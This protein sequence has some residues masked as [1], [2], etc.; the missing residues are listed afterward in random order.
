MLAVEHGAGEAARADT[1]ELGGQHQR[2][3]RH[4]AARGAR[5]HE[6]RVVAPLALDPLGQPAADGLDALGGAH[7]RQDPRR[8]RRPVALARR[9]AADHDDGAR[10]GQ[11]VGRTVAGRRVVV[12]GGRVGHAADEGARLQ[13]DALQRGLGAGRQAHWSF[14]C[15]RPTGHT[16]MHSK[17]WAMESRKKPS[18]SRLLVKKSPW[19][20]ACRRSRSSSLT[21]CSSAF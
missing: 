20:M 2:D 15:L 3:E 6:E 13:R 18:A 8:G 1:R 5:R 14:R 21:I 19:I 17:H 4:L 9:G 16:R 11:Q 12:E 10:A 7:R